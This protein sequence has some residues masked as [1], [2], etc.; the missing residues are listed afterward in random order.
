MPLCNFLKQFESN[1][2][3]AKKYFVVISQTGTNALSALFLQICT[4][5]LWWQHNT[6]NMMHMHHIGNAVQYILFANYSKLPFC[7]FL[8]LFLNTASNFPISQCRQN[9]MCNTGENNL[10]CKFTT[11]PHT[12]CVCTFV[13]GCTVWFFD[14]PPVNFYEDWTNKFGL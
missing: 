6:T 14:P 3:K 1:T 13:C 5:V 7:S 9:T 10:L 2:K 11:E 4:G 8:Q 12:L